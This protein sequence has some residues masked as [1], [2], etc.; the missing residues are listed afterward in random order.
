MRRQ[1]GMGVGAAGV[2]LSM[3]GCGNPNALLFNDSFINYVSGGIVPQTPGPTGAFVLVRAVNST[4]QNIQFVVTAEITRAA[5]DDEGNQQFDVNGSLITETVL[6]TVRLNT[7]PFGNANELGHVFACSTQAIERIGLGD[8]LLATDQGLF[9]GFEVGGNP[10]F[11]V[12]AGVNPLDRT[13][14]NFKCGDT[15]IL[16]AIE[17]TGIP[18]GV[19]VDSFVLPWEEQPE[20]C[21]GPDT[22]QN[23]E[24]LLENSSGGSE[25]P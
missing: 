20:C 16:R 10:G 24:A 8:N 5:L 22:F 25:E 21:V 17:S 15:V 4:Q 7:F 1:L 3:A 6:E 18:G 12:S 11:G 13:E 9:V 2:L 19:A 14:G 23:L